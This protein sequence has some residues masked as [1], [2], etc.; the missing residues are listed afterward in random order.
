M[1]FGVRPVPIGN[2]GGHYMIHQDAL[3]LLPPISNNPDDRVYL[4]AT[5]SK[6]IEHTGSLLLPIES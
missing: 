1:G 4:D 2:L 6:L 5:D 3:S